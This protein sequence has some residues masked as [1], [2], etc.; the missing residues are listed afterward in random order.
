MKRQPGCYIAIL[1]APVMLSMSGCSRDVP[2]SSAIRTGRSAERFKASGRAV[3]FVVPEAIASIRHLPEMGILEGGGGDGDA[4]SSYFRTTDANR[5]F[6][7]GFA[8][9]V[10]P[11]FKDV[12]SARIVLRETRAG[13]SYPLPPDRHELSYYTDVDLF[14]NTNDFDRPTSP[15]GTFETDGNLPQQKFEFDVARL[16]THLRGAKIGFR[17]KLDADPTYAGMGFLG[18]A[19]SGSSTPSGVRIEVTT[20]PAEA[21]DWLQV[22]IGKDHLDLAVA[23]QDRRPGQNPRRRGTRREDIL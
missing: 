14:V 11:R 10:I 7:R 16:V 17:V 5:E 1:L 20:T 8:E 18:T 19:F 21:N 22:R 13:T 12:F 3:T 9:F 4:Q 23:M 15:L 6:R 2:T